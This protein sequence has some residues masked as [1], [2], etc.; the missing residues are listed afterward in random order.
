[1]EFQHMMN[2]SLQKQP[3]LAKQRAHGK[4]QKETLLEAENG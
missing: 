4:G 1:M 3:S 2:A